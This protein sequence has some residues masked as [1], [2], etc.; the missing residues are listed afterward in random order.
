MK[1]QSPI[2]PKLLYLIYSDISIPAVRVCQPPPSCRRDYGCAAVVVKSLISLFKRPFIFRHTLGEPSSD[3]DSELSLSATKRSTQPEGRG[4]CLGC[5]SDDGL[6]LFGGFVG[7]GLSE[8]G[9]E[10][11]PGRED[12]DEEWVGTD[13]YRPDRIDE[14]EEFKPEPLNQGASSGI[15][16]NWMSV[17]TGTSEGEEWYVI[18]AK[19]ECSG[20]IK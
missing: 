15:T 5:A 19:L 6:I 2:K 14:D 13:W 8:P 11:G 12:D 1:S 4:S 18:I 17:L 7:I 9:R 3:S 10:G 16:G 20:I